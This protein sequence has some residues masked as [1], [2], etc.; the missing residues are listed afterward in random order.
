MVLDQGDEKGARNFVHQA[1]LLQYC[2]TLGR[3]GVAIFFKRMATPGH[4]AREGFE[5]DVTNT[6]RKI[7][8]MAKRDAE[9]RRDADVDGATERVQ[10]YPGS[11]TSFHIQVPP[12]GIEHDEARK[13]RA[14]FEVFAPEMRTALESGSLYEINKVL[15][16]MSVPEAEHMVALLNEVS[17]PSLYLLNKARHD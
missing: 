17:Q 8:D 16:G 4:P 3:D 14:M 11:K 2:R 7:R 12:P 5:K 1:L 6:F 13:T 9:R 15:V 10:L